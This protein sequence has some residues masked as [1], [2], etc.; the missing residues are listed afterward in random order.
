ML[1]YDA[2]CRN[3]SQLS[4]CGSH[5]G[6]NSSDINEV[7]RPH[8]STHTLCDNDETIHE[9]EETFIAEKCKNSPDAKS[10]SGRE[11]TNDQIKE[12]M[13]AKRKETGEKAHRHLSDQSQSVS[14]SAS[15]SAS[16]TPSPK[17]ALHKTESNPGGEVKSR[18]S[19]PRQASVR[20]QITQ[21]MEASCDLTYRRTS[22][23]SQYE[24]IRFDFE[25]G[26]FFMLGSPLG[27]VLAYRRM[28]SG[29]G[30]AGW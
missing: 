18:K 10:K 4:R 21:S 11:K 14:S 7:E 12:S 1:T 26:D 17:P 16:N 5:Y 27:L 6:S 2:L 3:R 29:D 25:V 22:M 23:E 28:F 13:I 8:G 24:H 19:D 9:E 15:A 20:L 30:K